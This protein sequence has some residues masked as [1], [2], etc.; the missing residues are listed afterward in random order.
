MVDF[1]LVF[2]RRKIV[3]F[4]IL[5][6]LILFMTVM[7][8]M[9]TVLILF[10]MLLICLVYSL[11][12][13]DIQHER[14]NL[15][16]IYILKVFIISIIWVVSTVYLPYI[17]FGKELG[18]VSLINLIFRQLFFIA[19]IALTFDLRDIQEDA[20]NNLSTIPVILGQKN[21]KVVCLM[22][23]GCSFLL[24]MYQ[25][26]TTNQELLYPAFISI[27]VTMLLIYFSNN[28]RDRYYYVF[29]LDGMCLFQYFITLG[30]NLN[31]A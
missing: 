20:K 13:I 11:P 27:T 28:Q 5:G 14:K 30:F 15:R 22:L 4:T 26:V 12:L 18:I 21:A 31:R 3:L 17:E 29:W 24:A 19:S 1:R 10:V 23:L 7:L 25:Q 16:E 2:N 8:K 6:L 9:N